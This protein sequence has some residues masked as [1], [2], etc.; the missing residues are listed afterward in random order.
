[1]IS[2]LAQA[3]IAWFLI[4]IF[5]PKLKHT[6][7]TTSAFWAFLI[8]FSLTATFQ[9][10][11]VSEPLEQWLGIH[12]AISWVMTYAI[13]FPAL[14]FACLGSAL[15]VDPTH[16]P[17]PKWLFPY[18][19]ISA[20]V[21]A[22]YIPIFAQL[23]SL[24]EAVVVY[25]WR[26]S[27][28][29]LIAFSYVLIAFSIL[30]RLQYQC[31]Q[32]AVTRHNRFRY[33]LLTV[34]VFLAIFSYAIRAPYI[35]ITTFWPSFYHTTAA[36]MMLRVG[37]AFGILRISWL[38]FFIPTRVYEL[39][40]KPTI[41]VEKRLA[42]HELTFLQREITTLLPLTVRLHIPPGQ[43]KKQVDQTLCH[44]TFSLM[45]AQRYFL[46]KK[47]PKGLTAVDQCR[48]T[49]LHNI[50]TSIPTDDDIDTLVGDY[51]VASQRYRHALRSYKMS[52]LLATHPQTQA[53]QQTENAL[54][55][56]HRLMINLGLNLKHFDV[57]KLVHKVE[58]SKG[59]KIFIFTMPLAPLYGAWLSDKEYPHEYIFI[60]SHLS[61]LHQL[62]VQLHEIGHI[63]CGHQTR[64]V[65]GQDMALLEYAIKTKTSSAF[66]SELIAYNPY[67]TLQKQ[68]S[69]TEAEAVA[70]VA[71]T[72]L[73]QS[74]RTQ[75]PVSSDNDNIEQILFE[76]GVS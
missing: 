12:G 47:M 50:L 42:V 64:F 17:L 73:L 70:V 57:A 44:L 69:E 11:A 22:L 72:Q 25:D 7:K 68:L 31:H 59:R 41:Y 74:S 34:C 29:R 67:D 38:F 60:N 71:H 3:F 26:I 24:A 37:N 35:L 2:P 4:L 48:Y 9:V 45:D 8:L 36:A 46:E 14:Y 10:R 19:M 56:A 63:I 18:A 39:V 65:T 75:T 53:Y 27:L 51:K 16:P 49:L 55:R 13:S 54:T 33:Q 21:V 43:V 5:L 62:H 76:M 30:L 61:I 58:Q 20:A 28:F 66:L 23:T 32:R 15:V 52:Q 6:N 40:M 1:M